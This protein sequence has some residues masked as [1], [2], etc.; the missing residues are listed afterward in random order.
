MATRSAASSST[1]A[2][3][4]G[5]AQGEVPA[6]QRTRCFL[7]RRGLYRSPRSGG[8][9]RPRPR[10][11]AAQH[12][13][14]D[15]AVQRLPDPAGLE[16]L[17]LR[18]DRIC[19]NTEKVAAYLQGH[20]KV[21]WVNYAGLPAHRTTRW[22]T[23]TCKARPPASSPLAS[24]APTAAVQKPGALPGCAATVHAPG[25]YRRQQVAGLPPGVDHTPPAGTGGTGQ[26]R[27]FRGDGS[28]VGR[29]R[30]YRRSACRSGAGAGCG[31]TGPRHPA[32]RA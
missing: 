8:L 19:A 10:R 31:L 15:F 11:A 5:R 13:R 30:A 21:A 25:Q 4:L 2:A 7:P 22:S 27:R 3:S 16:T 28:P 18:M 12:G 1:A 17:P 9:H 29:H 23:N 24:R 6:A 32:M 26:S 20:A 14:G